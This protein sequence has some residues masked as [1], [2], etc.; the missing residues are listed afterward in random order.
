[1]NKSGIYK[2]TC[3]PNSKIYIGSS[4]N[5]KARILRHFSMLRGD[6]HPNIN[7]QAS[8]NKYG[9]DKFICEHIIYCSED[10][11]L[12][13]EQIAID[14]IKPEF[15][16]ALVAGAPNKG[17]VF[18]QEVRDKISKSLIGNTRTLGFKHSE[19]TRKAMPFRTPGHR[20]SI[21]Y[22][23]TD[24]TREKISK[25]GKGRINSDE[26]KAKIAEKKRQ[27][28]ADKKANDPEYMKAISEKMKGNSRGKMAKDAD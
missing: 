7:L 28:W 2:I 25:A 26:S 24:E 5:I 14:G 20:F 15:N 1:M 22:S 6:R 3:T 13:Y 19:A 16:V 23:P 18:S 17:R 12:L 27:W 4:K 8:F 11:L 10:N 21:G 9:A